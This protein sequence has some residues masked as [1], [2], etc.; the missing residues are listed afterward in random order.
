MNGVPYFLMAR[1]IQLSR[2]TTAGSNKPK[3]CTS[4]LFNPFGE[5]TMRGFDNKE[6]ILEVV[7]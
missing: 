7:L 2:K 6:L 5:G 3:K 4:L 1:Q